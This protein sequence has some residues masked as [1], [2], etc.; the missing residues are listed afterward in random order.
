MREHGYSDDYIARL[1]REIDMVLSNADTNNWQSYGEIYQDYVNQGMTKA[2][3]QHRLVHLGII[4]RFDERGEFPD[5]KTRQRIVTRS[6]EQYLLPEFKRIIDTYRDFEL[7]RGAKKPK[8]IY[9]ESSVA[10]NFLYALQS[11]GIREVTEI[12]QQSVI[13]MFMKEDGTLRWGHSYKKALTA[14]FK[15][16]I[17]INQ[18]LFTLLVAYLPN[19]RETRKNIQYLTDY[20]VSEIKRVLAEG[21]S[22]L[23][24]RNRA[25]VRLALN[26]GLR[27]C[28]IA[29]LKLGDVDLESDKIRIS[30][31]KTSVPMELPLTAAAG[32]AVYDYVTQERPNS[33]SEYVF[34][35]E[36]RPFDRLASGSLWNIARKTMNIVGI[37]QNIGDRRGLHIFRHRLATE[38]L[39]N[40]VAR[41]VISRIAG[42][43]SP[44]SLEPYL[45]ADFKHLKE[46]AI[47]IERFPLRK[48]V[49]ADA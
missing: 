8:T 30:Q 11:A 33:G 21:N 16:N 40:G 3:L 1:K 46:C 20:E 9:S 43:A 36:R 17:P 49:F 6:K 35:S 41:P 34:V 19:L 28:D 45:S 24:L 44:D 42:H 4:E 31:Q 38:L 7:R 37:R 27:C 39:G 25:I 29:A 47:S 10:S 15:A 48:E 22:V 2:A 12:T 13:E 18:E 26:Y 32:N 5:G 14:V 23:S